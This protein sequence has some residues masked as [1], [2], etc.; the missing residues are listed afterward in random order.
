MWGTW[1]GTPPGPQLGPG[2][3]LHS[4]LS[5][6]LHSVQERKLQDLEVELETRT[7]DVKA[8]MAQ[9]DVQVRE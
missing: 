3:W 9:L 5:L 6:Y 1:S 7:K 8:R 2:H 4:H